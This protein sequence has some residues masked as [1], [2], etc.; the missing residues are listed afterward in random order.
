MAS[1]VVCSCRR[2]A[3]TAVAACTARAS[4]TG[5]V[6]PARSA[7]SPTLISSTPVTSAPTTIGTAT[8]PRVGSAGS[9]A[10]P[11]MPSSAPWMRPKRAVRPTTP[12]PIATGSRPTGASDGPVLSATGSSCV[13][14]SLRTQTTTRSAR[15]ISTTAE[16]S[17][18]ST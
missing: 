18:R 9:G 1:T 6:L 11:S 16:H 12:S 14:S 15:V 5:T 7:G 4:S 10:N 8:S 13:P 17:P 3:L 2:A